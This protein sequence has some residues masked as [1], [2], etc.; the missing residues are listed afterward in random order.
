MSIK[1]RNCP[2]WYAP[3]WQDIHIKQDPAIHPENR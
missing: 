3:A 1:N 2:L